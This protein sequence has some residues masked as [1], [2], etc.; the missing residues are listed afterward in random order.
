MTRVTHVIDG[1]SVGGAEIM[2]AN[3]LATTDLEEFPSEVIS[4]T[5]VGPVAEK[6][7]AAGVR[8][9]ALGLRSRPSGLA[10]LRS[11][12]RLLRDARP[13][14][15]QTWLYHADLL[16]GLGAR[17]AARGAPVVWGIHRSDVDRPWTKR[18]IAWAARLGAMASSRV[19]D[20]IICCSQVAADRHVAFGYDRAKIEVV[21]NGFDTSAFAPD[22]RAGQR[23]REE[24]GIGPGTQLVGMVARFDP[25]KD[26]GTFLRAAAELAPL[27]PSAH[28]VLC[29][30][31]VIADN[32]FFSAFLDAHPPLRGRVHLLGPRT[33]VPRVDAALSVAVLSSVGGEAFPLAVGEAMACGVPCVVTDVGDAAELVGNTGRVVP[34]ADPHALADALGALLADPRTTRELGAAARQRVV[35]HFEIHRVVARYE[36]IYRDVIAR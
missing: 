25:Q 6:I 21:P 2:L 26:H 13:D 14:V 15:V 30:K 29:G 8:V 31:D 11:L 22:A 9:R 32:P 5:D 16:G 35:E 1:L 3:L 24:L 12:P 28:F 19:P 4:L 20:R 18:R 10:A 17:L 34:P 7:E 36:A 27:H 23:I 33:D